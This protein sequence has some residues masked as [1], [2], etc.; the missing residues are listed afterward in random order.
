MIMK[1]LFTLFLSVALFAACSSDDP[2]ARATI[3]G[4][5]QNTCPETTVTLTARAEG[6]VSFQWRRNDQPISGQTAST[7]A[8]TQSGTYTVA[9]VNA[10]GVGQF[11]AP[12]NVTIEFCNEVPEQATIDGDDQNTCPETTVILTA[13]A[14]GATSFQWR[15]DG[16]N[17]SGITSATYVVTESGAYTVAGVN[18]EGTGAFSA[19]KNVTIEVCNEAPE[20]ATIAGDDQNTCPETTVTLTATAEGAASFQWRKDGIE[21][22]GATD[23]TFV[24]TESGA[25]TVAGVNAEGT[26]AFSA[27]KNVT[28]EVCN[29]APE[30][31][32]IAG[33][34]ENECPEDTVTLEATA[35][36]ATSFQWRKDG[37]DIS[38]ATN[39]IYVVEESGAYTVAG[40]NA[41]GTGAFSAAKNVTI[42]E[43]PES[44]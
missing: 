43:C 5:D 34:D 10:E 4:A 11:S 42:N 12:K 1:K 27:A 36:G 18:A 37:T 13:T 6:A 7:Y 31:A 35:K 19:A 29:E 15:K 17:I 32:T 20:Q 24:V 14:E 25:Y 28:I 39:A 8:V 33:A 38:G 41:E 23:A 21:I 40:V 9:G 26:G 3:T 16:T 44:R 2:P 30:Q 22:S